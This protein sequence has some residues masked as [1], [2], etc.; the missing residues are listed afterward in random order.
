MTLDKIDKELISLLFHDDGRETYTNLGKEL[1]I[2]RGKSMSHVSV[3]KRIESLIEDQIV[4]IQANVN[5]K[6]LGYVSAFILLETEDYETQK[7]IIERFR[8]C[9]RVF[10]IDLITGKYNIVIRA[11]AKSLDEMQ[12]FLNMSW[13]KKESLRNLEILISTQNVK[14]NYLPVNMRPTKCLQS[15]RGACGSKCKYCEQFTDGRCS[16]CPASKFD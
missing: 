16:G 5:V 11:V 1:E 7:R 4:K 2:V 12:C 6:K 9:P 10:S 13:I 3:K 8:L 15:N 14:P